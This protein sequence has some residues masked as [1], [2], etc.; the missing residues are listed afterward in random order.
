MYEYIPAD[1]VENSFTTKMEKKNQ[2][3]DIGDR[4]LYMRTT[5]A[6]AAADKADRNKI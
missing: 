4:I 1:Y 6:A 2:R 3:T 5:V